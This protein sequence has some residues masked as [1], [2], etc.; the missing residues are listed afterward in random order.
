MVHRVGVLFLYMFIHPF[1]KQQ[2][3][4]TKKKSNVPIAMDVIASVAISMDTM[5]VCYYLLLYHQITGFYTRYTQ[6]QQHC[7]QPAAAVAIAVA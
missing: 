2:S 5:F 3:N 4:N 1:L 6:N 7:H